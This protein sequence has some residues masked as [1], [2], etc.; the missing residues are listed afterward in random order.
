MTEFLTVTDFGFKSLA[1]KLAIAIVEL[2][3]LGVTIVELAVTMVELSVTSFAK[4][5]MSSFV[6]AI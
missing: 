4:L 3:E 5:F 1:S 2:G 6:V